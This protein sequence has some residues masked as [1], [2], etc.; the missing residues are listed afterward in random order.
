MLVPARPLQ[1]AVRVGLRPSA[2][3]AAFVSLSLAIGPSEMSPSKIPKPLTLE[4]RMR[5]TL[6]DLIPEIS[7]VR[8]S[9][10]LRNS[11][12]PTTA[13]LAAAGFAGELCA[14]L[15][16][17]PP[18]ALLSAS[19]A[20][21]T[22]PL[23]PSPPAVAVSSLVESSSDDFPGDPGRLGGGDINGLPLGRTS[24]S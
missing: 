1:A 5:L 12:E 9:A 24:R 19:A 23:R 7:P 16:V 14:P 18:P 11:P 21:A 10:E 17:W 6:N 22:S 13:S 3:A 4:Y 20:R 2:S 8:R 15:G